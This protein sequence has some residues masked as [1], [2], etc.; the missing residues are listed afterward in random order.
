M[1]TSKTVHAEHGVVDKTIDE[2]EDMDIDDD[3]GDDMDD[4]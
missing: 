2:D 4:V 1:S 3:E